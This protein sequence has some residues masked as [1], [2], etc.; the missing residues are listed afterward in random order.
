MPLRRVARRDGNGP[1]VD[2]TLDGVLTTTVIGT[3]L[4]GPVLARNPDLADELLHRATGRRLT[5]LDVPGQ[6]AARRLH[7][8]AR[9]GRPH[10]RA[11]RSP[12]K[13]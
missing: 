10:R 8:S 2:G 13:G 4:H 12:S 7:L 5:P 1:P 6:D 9:R 3:Y 11:A